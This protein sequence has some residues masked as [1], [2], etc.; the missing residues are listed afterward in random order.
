MSTRT[1][2]RPDS[3]CGKRGLGN[4][5]WHKGLETDHFK[6]APQERSRGAM[7]AAL[8]EHARPSSA[9][10]PGVCATRRPITRGYATCERG[11]SRSES[12][13]RWLGEEPRLSTQ[14]KGTTQALTP[15]AAP[16]VT[17]GQEANKGSSGVSPP[18]QPLEQAGTTT[19][20]SLGLRHKRINTLG[21]NAAALRS[22]DHQTLC[23]DR[24]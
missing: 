14:G 2:S 5:S 15:G 23:E 12:G 24:T 4:V 1:M 17:L 7:G 20:A 21:R 16:P 19:T 11:L 10:A 13:T 3:P 18:L 8:A 6:L 22:P 9:S